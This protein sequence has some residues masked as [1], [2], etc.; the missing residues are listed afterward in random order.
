QIPI[1]VK[2]IRMP[3]GANKEPNQPLVAY[4]V[5]KV[6]PVTEVGKANGKSTIEF[7]KPLPKKSYR[8]KTHAIIKPNK[9]F[10]ATA[11]NDKNNVKKS[12]YN[13]FSEKTTEKK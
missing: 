9:I 1:F 3:N 4:N 5:A 12:A 10:V 8:T 2:A 13:T 11:K 7:N 6:I